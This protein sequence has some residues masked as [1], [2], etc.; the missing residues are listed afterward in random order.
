MEIEKHPIIKKKKFS[1]RSATDRYINLY[2]EEFN[3]YVGLSR[4]LS[5]LGDMAKA[6]NQL[7]RRVK[8]NTP[9]SRGE[10]M[11]LNAGS[12]W[13]VDGSVPKLLKR[14]N[15]LVDSYNSLR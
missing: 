15:D 12:G 13:M 3:S 2:L 4:Y 7:T 11:S 10:K 1:S 5:N 8:N 14:Y 6:S 9:F